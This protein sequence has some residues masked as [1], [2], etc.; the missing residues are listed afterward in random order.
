MLCPH[1]KTENSPAS[2]LCKNCGA[3]LTDA[4]TQAANTQPVSLHKSSLDAPSGGIPITENAMGA[5]SNGEGAPYK[6]SGRY[7]SSGVPLLIVAGIVSAILVGLLYFFVS[8]FINLILI[9]PLIAGALVGFGITFAVRAGKIRNPKLVGTVAVL[10]GLLMMNTMHMAR[11]W[12]ARPD[13]IDGFS[14]LEIEDAAASAKAS[15]TAL[16]PQQLAALEKNT[17]AEIAGIMTP[18][19]TLTIY[20]QLA[21]LYMNCLT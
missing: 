21:A 14:Q 4:A 8:Q 6:A 3:S 19:R 16:T 9:F 15:G 11:A 2:L 13:M 7:E 1:C 20:E 17:R 5:D 10:A 12:S 18:F